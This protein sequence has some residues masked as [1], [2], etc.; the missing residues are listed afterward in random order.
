M[1]FF[2][3]VTGLPAAGKS[4]FARKITK[5]FNLN[6][7]RTDAIRDFLIKELNYYHD[8]QYSHS[9]PKISSANVIVK[10][11]KRAIMKELLTQGQTVLLDSVGKEKAKRDMNLEFIRGISKDIKII[12]MVVK[13]KEEDVLSRLKKR[14]KSGKTKWIETYKTRWSKTY[15]E[16]TADEADYLI[17]VEDY[18]K[19][20]KE[21]EKIIR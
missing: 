19:A 2:I 4:H 16:P 7:I 20:I 11:I 21:L 15:D 13:A 9:N 10:D 3:G 5:K 12:I 18:D 14:D 17:I 6:H 1:T 8:T